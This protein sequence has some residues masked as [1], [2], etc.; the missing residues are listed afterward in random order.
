MD[1]DYRKALKYYIYNYE[2]IIL[3]KKERNLY[4]N[5]EF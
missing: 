1:E 2:N 5:T 4:K 3:N